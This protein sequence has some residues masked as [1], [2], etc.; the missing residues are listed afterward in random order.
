[1]GKAQQAITTTEKTIAEEDAGRGPSSASTLAV[2]DLV[3]GCWEV[4][5]MHERVQIHWRLDAVA[6]R[7]TFWL[8]RAGAAASRDTS[9]DP[10]PMCMV[11]QAVHG[12]AQRDVEL[13]GQSTV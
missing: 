6:T 8:S 3:P 11:V 13:A 10:R 1:M 5:N 9:C 7:A 12:V 2:R 4:L